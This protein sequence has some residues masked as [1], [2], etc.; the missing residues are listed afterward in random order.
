M[1][2]IQATLQHLPGVVVH[3]H[4]EDVVV[5][6]MTSADVIQSLFLAGGILKCKY[7]TTCQDLCTERSR[8]TYDTQLKSP[9]PIGPGNL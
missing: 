1:K 3:W 6:K 9:E 7:T 8:A 4:T 2:I 5:R